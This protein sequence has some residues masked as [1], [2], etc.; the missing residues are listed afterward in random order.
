[1][2]EVSLVVGDAWQGRGVGTAL[3]R[4]HAKLAR[5]R[6]IAG[7]TADVLPTNVPMLALFSESG[8]PVESALDRGVCRVRL[9][10]P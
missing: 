5:A 1:M 2:A 9:V 7:L 10:F 3:F 4:R 6:G 8:F